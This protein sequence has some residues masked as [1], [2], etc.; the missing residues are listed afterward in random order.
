MTKTYKTIKQSQVCRLLAA[1]ALLVLLLTAAACTGGETKPEP[2]TVTEPSQAPSVTMP[3]QTTLPSE[4]EESKPTLPPIRSAA[5]L[6][7]DENGIASWEGDFEEPLLLMCK[8]KWVNVRQAPSVE[9]GGW[10]TGLTLGQQV[11]SKGIVEGWFHVTV[12]PGLREGYVRSD[13]LIDYDPDRLFYARIPQEEEIIEEEDGS[14]TILVNQ[15]VDLRLFAPDI[16][17]FLVFATPDNYIGRPLYSRDTCLIQE[18]TAKKLAK[19]QEMVKED[20]YRIRVYDAYRPSSV[21]GILFKQVPDPSFVSPA[22]KSYHNRGVSV[23]ITLVDEE[24]NELEMPSGV[25][26]L[27]EKARRNQPMTDEAKANLA[28]L[29]AVMKKCGFQSV[30]NEWWHY[31]DWDAKKFMVSD[32]D[33]TRVEYYEKTSR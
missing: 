22:G 32:L 12:L 13:L 14:Q 3:S 24:G 17:Y 19:A 11:L 31:T 21:S 30:S 7:R 16:D 6:P 33:F 28:Y 5:D 29:T 26:E 1:L 9:T 27:N 10:V 15:L 2:G 18:G 23:D 8:N 4:T 20:G 25:M